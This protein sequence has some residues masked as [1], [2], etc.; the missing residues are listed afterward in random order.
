ME[1]SRGHK[2]VQHTAFDEHRWRADEGR[3][4]Q[5]K[6][7]AKCRDTKLCDKVD[8]ESIILAKLRHTQKRRVN[9]CRS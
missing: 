4:K 3:R 1:G 7:T 9:W 2:R 5:K 8:G 6:E